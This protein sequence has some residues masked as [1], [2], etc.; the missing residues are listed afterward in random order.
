LRDCDAQER[1]ASVKTRPALESSIPLPQ[2][3][4]WGG[5]LYVEG[6]DDH[7]LLLARLENLG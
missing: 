6:N 7:L 1:L 5:E 3:M 4:G 2:A